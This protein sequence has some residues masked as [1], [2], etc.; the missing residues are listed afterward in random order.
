MLNSIETLLCY[1]SKIKNT[2]G[3]YYTNGPLEGTN[4]KIKVVKHVDFGFRNFH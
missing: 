3:Y 4:S 1:H 2:F